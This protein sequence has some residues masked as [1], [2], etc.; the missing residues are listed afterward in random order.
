MRKLHRFNAFRMG[1]LLP[2]LGLIT[3]VGA[4][5]GESSSNSTQTETRCTTINGVEECT[6]ITDETETN[7]EF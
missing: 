2:M 6:E 7:R 3:L 1:L 4:C 5:S